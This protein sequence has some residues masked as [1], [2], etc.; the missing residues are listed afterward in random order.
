ML[1]FPL[2]GDGGWQGSITSDGPA[3]DKTIVSHNMAS[4]GTDVVTRLQG[5]AWKQLQHSLLH[6]TI[7]NNVNAMQ[8]DSNSVSR[9]I[10]DCPV[11][12]GSVWY[13][14]SR[15]VPNVCMSFCLVT[16]CLWQSGQNCRGHSATALGHCCST[17]IVQPC[18]LITMI[19]TMTMTMTM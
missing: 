17:F 4:T 8:T 9:P 19:I 14:Y 3:A 11:L 10:K 16:R 18:M 6:I 13:H 7:V 5:V 2:H 1:E 12:A 15:T